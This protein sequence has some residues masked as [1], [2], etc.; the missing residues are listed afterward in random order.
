M[1]T[2]DTAFHEVILKRSGNTYITRAL[3]NI[4]MLTRRF[5][6]MQKKVL[7]QLKDIPE[8]HRVILETLR[9]G[10]PDEV[11]AVLKTHILEQSL[12]GLLEW[13]HSGK[14]IL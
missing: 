3:K 4:T 9:R 10:D 14:K 13:M 11:S 2:A 1:L 5:S 8:R 7:H 6:F 12:E